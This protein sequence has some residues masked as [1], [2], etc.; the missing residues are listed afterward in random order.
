LLKSPFQY[1]MLVPQP[2]QPFGSSRSIV[3]L[4]MLF[5]PE[6]DVTW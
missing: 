4:L 2:G 5:Q 1:N 3:V 6:H